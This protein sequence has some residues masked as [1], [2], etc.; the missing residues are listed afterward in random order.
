MAWMR[1]GWVSG[2][3]L[4]AVLNAAAMFLFVLWSGGTS[5]IIGRT[6]TEQASLVL[7][8]SRT[9]NESAE[10]YV[11]EEEEVGEACVGLSKQMC[12]PIRN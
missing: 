7:G 2:F 11:V 1:S 9:L 6:M 5:N 10:E 8:M 3:F 12:V 4:G